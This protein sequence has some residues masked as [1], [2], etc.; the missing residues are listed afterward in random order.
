MLFAF[1]Q[2]SQVILSPFLAIKSYNFHVIWDG[3]YLGS[4][5]ISAF[6]FWLSP[7]RAHLKSRENYKTWLPRRET[8]SLDFAV[9]KQTTSKNLTQTPFREKEWR[10]RWGWKKETKVE[11]RVKRIWRKQDAD[12]RGKEIKIGL[13]EKLYR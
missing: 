13:F 10:W 2:Q 9:K 7:N 8:I 3:L 1:W 11:W 4:I 5:K 6:I 12:W